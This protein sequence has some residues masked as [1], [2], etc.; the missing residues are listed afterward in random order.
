MALVAD[1]QVEATGEHEILGVGRLSRHR[2]SS[3]AEFAVLVSDKVQGRGLGTELVRRL[4]E[5]GRAEGIQ[6]ITAE[7]LPKNRGMQRIC[8]RLGFRL[9]HDFKEQIVRVEIDLG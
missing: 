4:L 1:H 5:V 3:E 9:H 7:V 6:R 2:G 8:E